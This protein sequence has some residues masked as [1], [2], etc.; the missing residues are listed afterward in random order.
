MACNSL[1]GLDFRLIRFFLVKTD[2]RFPLLTCLFLY[3]FIYFLKKSQPACG[4][5]IF[6]SL[7]PAVFS[8]HFHF[9]SCVSYDLNDDR[10]WLTCRANRA[11]RNWRKFR[12]FSK[13]KKKKNILKFEKWHV[14]FRWKLPPFLQVHCHERA[15]LSNAV[16]PIKCQTARHSIDVGLRKIL[17]NH[18]IHFFLFPPLWFVDRHDLNYHH[19]ML[20]SF[21]AIGPLVLIGHWVQNNTTFRLPLDG[22]DWQGAGHYLSAIFQRKTRVTNVGLYSIVLWQ[23]VDCLLHMSISACIFDVAISFLIFKKSFFFCLEIGHLYF[24]SNKL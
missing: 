14:C 18:P 17:E 10:V 6:I 15:R 21:P 5:L 2:P 20:L 13:K 19:G 24:E 11:L 7:L 12:P 16:S 22:Q 9:R 1:L 23:V 4:T 3:L 8:Q